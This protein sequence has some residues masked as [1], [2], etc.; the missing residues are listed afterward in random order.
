MR[1]SAGVPPATRR[2]D[3]RHL[4]MVEYERERTDGPRLPAAV[5]DAGVQAELVE[6]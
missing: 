2:A 5:I 6:R 3:R 1:R 4:I